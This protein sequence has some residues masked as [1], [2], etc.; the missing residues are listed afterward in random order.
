MSRDPLAQQ[1]SRAPFDREPALSGPGDDPLGFYEMRSEQ[2]PITSDNPENEKLYVRMRKWLDVGEA[3]ALLDVGCSDGYFLSRFVR[4]TQPKAIA[5]L[6]L[7]PSRVKLA[8]SLHANLPIRFVA[9]SAEELPFESDSF[10]RVIV[11][12][13]I[14]HVPDDERVLREVARVACKGALVYVTFPNALDAMLPIFRS[15]CRKVDRI[16]GHLRR[17]H[18]ADVEALARS[19]GFEVVQLEYSGFLGVFLWYSVVIYNPIVKRIGLKLIGS[20]GALPK[21][22]GAQTSRKSPLVSLLKAGVF[23]LMRFLDAVDAPF[24]Q[25]PLSLGIHVLLR[26]V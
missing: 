16:E 22:E 10:S 15:Y 4:D 17:Y 21:N 18:A 1:E 26:R 5:G 12:E 25:S 8:Q 7:S 6:D 11:N 20:P 2:K 3:D 14:E 24:R 23:G 13:V 19:T 9:G